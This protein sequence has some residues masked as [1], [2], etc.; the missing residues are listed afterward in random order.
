MSHAPANEVVNYI[1]NA[2]L[3]QQASLLSL[4]CVNLLSSYWGFA[5]SNLS[6]SL[7]FF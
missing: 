5:K 7:L 3:N 1:P 2:A 6:E 4:H